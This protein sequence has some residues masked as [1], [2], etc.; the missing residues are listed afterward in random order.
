MTTQKSG[1]NNVTTRRRARNRRARAEVSPRV[2]WLGEFAHFPTTVHG[3]GRIAFRCPASEIKQ[4]IVETMR[5]LD[6][7]E[8]F[9]PLSISGL[10]GE[11][12]GRMGF[13]VGVA[14]GTVFERLDEATALALREYV[15]KNDDLRILDFILIATYHYHEDKRQLPV[16]FD[17]HH[18]RFSFLPREKVGDVLIHHIRGTRRL[19]FDELLQTIFD[20]LQDVSERDHLGAV[21]TQVV[22]TF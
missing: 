18:I 12:D 11:V 13:E 2:N 20:G 8:Q 17:H 7:R 14:N 16:R 19:P 3:I 22:K 15:S 1:N 4:A 9:V 5:Q 6:G 10:Q 21:R